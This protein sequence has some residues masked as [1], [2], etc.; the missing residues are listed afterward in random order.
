[1]KNKKIITPLLTLTVM[2]IGALSFFAVPKPALAVDD[3]EWTP[4]ISVPGSS[5]T[6]GSPTVMTERSTVY[7]GRYISAFYDYGIA[8]VGIVAVIVLMIGGII[9]LTSGGSPGKIGQAKDLITGSIAGMALLLCSWML[10][11][12]INPD[13]VN[14]KIQEIE[15]IAEKPLNISQ[16]VSCSDATASS[17]CNAIVFCAWKDNMCVGK[18]EA[19][20]AKCSTNKAD[21]PGPQICC[22]QTSP[23]GSYV[24]CNWATYMGSSMGSGNNGAPGGGD[25]VA[26]G[27]QYTKIPEGS[28]YKCA[29]AASTQQSS[30]P[31]FTSPT[32][33]CAEK[34]DESSCRF[35]QLVTMPGVTGQVPI[36]VQGYCLNKTCT[37]CRAI[38]S[39]CGDSWYENYQCANSEGANAS[40]GS[41]SHGNCQNKLNGPNICILN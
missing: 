34:E 40:C 19:G 2:I 4:S 29:E 14:F 39:E 41:E 3:I 10:L 37:K 24:S 28:E 8:I 22:C 5:F 36:M 31:S 27:T 26:C 23:A 17:T 38:G 21:V 15:N 35:N 6:A 18:I 13:L 32:E 9:W 20:L 12:T 7:I 33:A 11:N 16:A 30:T 25:C 1:M